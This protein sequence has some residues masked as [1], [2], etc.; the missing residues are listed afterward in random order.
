MPEPLV[1][2]NPQAAATRGINEN[3]WVVI[4]TSEGTIQARAKFNK[5]LADDVICC[6]YGWLQ[7]SHGNYNNIISDSDFDPISSSNTLRNFRCNITKAN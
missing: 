7:N 6:Q 2:L 1:E 3:D 4:E 5:S